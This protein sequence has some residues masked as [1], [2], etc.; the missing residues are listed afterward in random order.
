M[1]CAIRWRPTIAASAALA[2]SAPAPVAL[3]PLAEADPRRQGIA[4]GAGRPQGDA[5]AAADRRIHPAHRRHRRQPAG[6]ARVA[7]A[8]AGA[9][10]AVAASRCRKRGEPQR[11][12]PDNARRYE[13][14]VQ[15]VESVEP[16]RAAATYRQLYPLFQQAWQE[17]GYPKGYF[18]DRLVDVIDHLLTTPQV[19]GPIEMTLT[20]IKGP[21]PSTTPWLRYEF[22]DPTLRGLSAGQKMLLRTGVVNERRMMDWLRRFRAQIAR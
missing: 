11:V 14:L 5:A 9:S 17:L 12:D 8:V 18:N 21:Y 19:E 4:D 2:A 3:P 22:V 7:A 15:L 13:P 20:E 10:D 1:R 16:T 6:Q